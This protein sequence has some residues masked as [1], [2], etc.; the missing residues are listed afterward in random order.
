[1]EVALAYDFRTAVTTT[2]NSSALDFAANLRRLPVAFEGRVKEPV[3]MRQ[4]MTGLHE[5][6]LGDFRQDINFWVLDPVITVHPDEIFFEAFSTDESAYARLSAR[7]EAFD[8]IGEPT[9][10]TT[11]I[12]FTFALRNAL[13]DLRSSRDTR[14]KVG[15]AGFGIDTQLSSATTN[16]HFENKVKLPDSWLKGFLQ[17]QAALTMNP[18]TFHVRPVDFL[19]VIHF[20][21]DN[22]ARR[23]PHGLRFEFKNGQNIQ[24]VLEPWEQRFTL[25]DTKYEGYDRS[26]RLWG[27]KRLELLLRILPYADKLTIGVLGR[28]LPHFYIAH[29]GSYKFTLVLSGWVRNDWSA[30]SA[31]DLMASQQ[32]ASPE[33]V[34]TVYSHLAQHLSGTQKDIEAHTL[35][36]GQAVESA[37]FYLSRAGRVMYDLVSRRYRSRELFP[38]PIDMDTIFAPDPRIAQ[39]QA[40]VDEGKVTVEK[41]YPSDVRVN[42][43]KIDGVVVDGEDKYQVLVAVDREARIRFAQCECA[44]FRE[45][46]M[47]RGPC[48]HI[49]AVRFA[50][51]EALQEHLKAHTMDAPT[52]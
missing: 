26:V 35:L 13:Q 38:E 48:E 14:F 6:I 33:V 34:A 22:V 3:L 21:M 1:M 7:T 46:I 10:G 31:F 12:D 44:F 41:I 8:V 18:F 27:R 9:Y 32:A 29:C 50:A 45:N 5:V 43:T 52:A 42:E 51:D 16:M 47:N 11:N 15:L 30:G 2:L 36:D 19:T 40:L 28:G 25:K 4:L 17:V 23:P 49:L 20:L 39:A 37:L 24:A